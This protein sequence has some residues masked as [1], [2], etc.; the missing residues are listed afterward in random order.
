MNVPT[1]VF[2]GLFL[3]CLVTPIN[4]AISPAPLQPLLCALPIRVFCLLL[5]LIVVLVLGM[6]SEVTEPDESLLTSRA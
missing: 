1:R 5:M 6:R 4:V 3:F 2:G